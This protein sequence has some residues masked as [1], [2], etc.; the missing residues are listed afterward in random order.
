MPVFRSL[1]VAIPLSLASAAL[2]V[3]FHGVSAAPDPTPAEPAPKAP[4][5][6]VEVKCVDDSTIRLKL[7]DDKLELVTKHGFLQVA[8]ADIRRIEFAHRCP[9]DVAEKIAAAI[10]KLGHPDFPTRERA[11]A[12]LKAYRERAYPFLLKAVKHDDPEVSRRADESVK[13]IQAKVP[14]AL[15]DARDND[16]V[17]TDDSKYTG[18]LTAQTLRVSTLLFGEQS[19]RV[20][21]LR[22]LR[23]GAAVAAEELRD[24]TPAPAT[25]AAFQ[26]QFGKELTFNLT[27]YTPGG[28]Q[29]TLWGT[30]LYTLDSSL[31]AA[32]VHAGVAKP[33]EVVSVRVRIVQSPPQYVASFRNGVNSTAYGNF[34]SGAFEFVRK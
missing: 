7:L 32:A 28:Q 13:Y 24:A 14:A 27:G 29:P 18:K 21:D 1:L 22:N 15:L 8:V 12:D 25:L 34:P 23:T 17:H 11:T 31:A 3:P 9:P 30:D 19:V 33:G 26:Q 2:F 10:S 20:A 16:V 4:G 6:D 5:L